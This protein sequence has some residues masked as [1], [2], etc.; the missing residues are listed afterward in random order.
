MKIFVKPLLFQFV[1][2]QGES[3]PLDKILR[4]ERTHQDKQY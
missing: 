3:K 4:G 1:I 2:I